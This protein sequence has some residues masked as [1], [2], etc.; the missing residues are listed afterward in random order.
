MV[1]WG[2]ENNFFF[3]R[4]KREAGGNERKEKKKFLAVTIFVVFG[5]LWVGGA[6]EL[7]DDYFA[8]PLGC[9]GVGSMD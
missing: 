6:P 5:C 7:S 8:G 2:M 3:A 4:E 9:N 1:A